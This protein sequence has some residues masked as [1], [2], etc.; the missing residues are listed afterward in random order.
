[1]A[2][3]YLISTHQPDEIAET[4][5][6]SLSLS[7]SLRSNRATKKRL[8]VIFG[9]LADISLLRNMLKVSRV[10]SSDSR[11]TPSRKGSA[12]IKRRSLVNCVHPVHERA[13]YRAGGRCRC[14]LRSNY[15]R[16]CV[17]KRRSAFRLAPFDII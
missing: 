14:I 15:F 6:L 13:N 16:Q 9:L 2:R 10:A 17:C 7:L 5:A 3:K 1:M 11:P 12:E 8:R 4:Y